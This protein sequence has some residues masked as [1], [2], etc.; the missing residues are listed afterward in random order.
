[1]AQVKIVA[2]RG[3]VKGRIQGPETKNRKKRKNRRYGDSP[4]LLFK[5]GNLPLLPVGLEVQSGGADDRLAFRSLEDRFVEPDIDL[6]YYLLV[7]SLYLRGER[8]NGLSP[9]C[10]GD[11]RGAQGQ[12]R[13]VA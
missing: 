1:M 11:P 12:E 5:M 4:P 2:L 6:R 9:V 3:N 8:D 10:C 7:F 13:S